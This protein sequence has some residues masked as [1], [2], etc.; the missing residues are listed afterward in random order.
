[1][2]WIWVIHLILRIKLYVGK[3]KLILL[4]TSNLLY[5]NVF[6]VVYHI[7]WWYGPV[8]ELELTDH[9]HYQDHTGHHRRVSPHMTCTVHYTPG[10]YCTV[11][12]VHW[13]GPYQ[14]GLWPTDSLS[15]EWPTLTGYKEPWPHYN[16]GHKNSSAPAKW[17]E[18]ENSDS[19]VENVSLQ[20]KPEIESEHTWWQFASS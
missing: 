3:R 6:C 15:D 1:M 12:T 20:Y 16:V 7:W 11:H 10:L 14:Q 5:S 8:T 13:C 4:I 19:Y 2:M 17:K 18:F 9:W